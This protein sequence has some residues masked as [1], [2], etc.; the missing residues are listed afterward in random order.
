MTTTIEVLNKRVYLA[1]LVP[2]GAKGLFLHQMEDGDILNEY[3]ALSEALEGFNEDNN[4][5][6]LM[7]PRLMPVFNANMPF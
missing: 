5:E 4:L 7:T 1:S 3:S 6:H 2:E